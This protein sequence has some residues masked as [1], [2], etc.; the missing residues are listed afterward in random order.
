MQLIMKGFFVSSSRR[1]REVTVFF[2]KRT[3]SK[4]VMLIFGADLKQ[5]IATWTMKVPLF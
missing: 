1:R 4:L 3:L 2:P 5:K